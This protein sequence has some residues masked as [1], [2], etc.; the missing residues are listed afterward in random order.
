MNKKRVAIIGA[1]PA[2]CALACFLAEKGIETVVY[3]NEKKPSLIVGE[4]NLPAI[5]PL[6]RRLKIEEHVAAIS[7]IKRGA[8]LRDMHGHRVD[9]RFRKFGSKYPDYSYNTPRPEFDRIIRQRAEALGVRFVNDKADLNVTKDNMERDLELSE[10]SLIQAGL[11]TETHP[12][13]LVD[14][15]GRTR[16]FSRLLKLS[17]KRGGRD[18]VSYFAHFDNFDADGVVEGQ[19]VLSV[20]ENGWSWQIPIKDKLSVGVVLD[21]K[22]ASEYGDNPEQRLHAVIEQNALL[23]KSGIK[24]SRE[25]SVMCYSNYQLISKQGFGK[26]WVLLGDAFG[27]V[28]PMLS[29]GVFMALKSAEILDELV[30]S[31]EKI[32]TENLQAYTQHIYEWHESWDSLISYFYDGRLLGL[33]EKRANIQ[34]SKN[35]FSIG[36]I[37]E[38]IFS[39]ALA[40]MV[41][42]VKT[43]SKFNQSLLF[44]GCRNLLRD[45]TLD[46]YAIKPVSRQL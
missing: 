29:P 1:G 3:D 42:G 7:N 17:T 25:T 32:K 31:Q 18:D 30:F 37:A 35:P 10:A 43:R 34:N 36:K 2:G 16:L 4:S 11:T 33:S 46:E 12:D 19:V 15:T 26:G 22:V 39:K 40:S 44:H 27:F 28:D 21:K 23:N 41:T 20:L 6:L 5:V 38:P 24:A 9:F 14:A 45:E 8:A 13:I